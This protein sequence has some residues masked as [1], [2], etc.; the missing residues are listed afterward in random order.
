MILMRRAGSGQERAAV[1]GLALLAS[2]LASIMAFTVLQ[3]AMSQARIGQFYYDRT[4]SRYAAEAGIVWAQQRLRADPAF[5][6]LLDGTAD[7]VLDGIG[8]DVGVP[9]CAPA[10]CRQTIQAK[11]VY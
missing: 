9:G 6:D 3:V 10:P 7:I 4:R 5:T 11:V 8:V 2:V 1:L